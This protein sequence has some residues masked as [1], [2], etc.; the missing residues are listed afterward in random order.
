[1]AV[2]K[3]SLQSASSHW[4]DWWSPESVPRWTGIASA[5]RSSTGLLDRLTYD[6][7]YELQFVITPVLLSQVKSVAALLERIVGASIALSWIPAR[8][9]DARIR[10]VHASAAIEGN[11]LTLEQV[12]ALE[13]GHEPDASD[14]RSRGWNR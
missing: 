8:Q 10:D 13:E 1:M 12:R 11:L 6:V 4:F 5:V 2:D 14:F 9:K 3:T 7:G